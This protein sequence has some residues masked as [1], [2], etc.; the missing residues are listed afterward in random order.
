M[1]RPNAFEITDQT[2]GETHVVSVLGELDLSTIT[3]LARH[4]EVKLS[5]NRTTSLVLDL[6][7]LTFMDSSGL[8]LL[9][10]LHNRSLQEAWKLTLIRSKH[11]GANTVLSVTGADT[12]LPF[13]DPTS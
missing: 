8:R 6:T 9:I 13:E 10:D 5:E 11:E 2:N 12:A 7:D 3:V 1:V 4:V